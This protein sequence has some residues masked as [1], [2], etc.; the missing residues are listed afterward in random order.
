MPSILEWKS[1]GFS[2]STVLFQTLLNRPSCLQFGRK[3]QKGAC[4]YFEWALT[5]LIGYQPAKPAHWNH[6]PLLILPGKKRKHRREETPASDFVSCP[7]KSPTIPV[8]QL[9]WLFQENF[10]CFFVEFP[11]F[12]KC[13]SNA[14][15][16]KL[17]SDSRTIPRVLLSLFFF[18]TIIT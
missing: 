8:T 10:C 9:R 17:N 7:K 4:C 6:P 11:V 3:N 18:L 14:Q 16:S 1:L 13:S 12:Q 2:F 5:D 15:I